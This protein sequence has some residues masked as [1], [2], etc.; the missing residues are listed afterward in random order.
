[1]STH[2]HSKIFN[3]VGTIRVSGNTVLPSHIDTNAGDKTDLRKFD[4]D[5]A[6]T[7]V[8]ARN[9]FSYFEVVY[10]VHFHILDVYYMRVHGMECRMYDSARNGMS[11]TRQ[12][13]E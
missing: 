6:V 8:G 12:G 2:R 13:T 5:P 3:Y 4:L 9:H 7:W 11:S 10:S 1:M